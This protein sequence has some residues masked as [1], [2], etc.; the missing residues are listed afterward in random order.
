L[1]L[2]SGLQPSPMEPELNSLQQCYIRFHLACYIIEPSTMPMGLCQ[3]NLITSIT[4]R[5]EARRAPCSL[6]AVD[7]NHE[8][9]GPRAREMTCPI[10]SQW[11]RH[12]AIA[13]NRDWIQVVQS[14]DAKSRVPRPESKMSVQVISSTSLHGTTLFRHHLQRPEWARRPFFSKWSTVPQ[15]RVTMDHLPGRMN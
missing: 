7:W 5:W 13:C 14:S 8:V 2:C 11:D 9:C 12:Q 1:L 15:Y 4:I 6:S 3:W 10:C